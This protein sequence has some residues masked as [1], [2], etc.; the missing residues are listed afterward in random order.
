[1][2]FILK[3]FKRLEDALNI[4]N[5]RLKYH[6]SQ[7]QRSARNQIFFF[8]SKE[9]FLDARENTC[10]EIRILLSAIFMYLKSIKIEMEYISH[11]YII[12]ANRFF[13]FICSQSLVCENSPR[14]SF[15]NAKTVGAVDTFAEEEINSEIHLEICR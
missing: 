14:R 13:Y 15:L 2:T 7:L 10:K 12:R 1:M 4:I 3:R 5:L 9:L 8:S 11:I 6:I